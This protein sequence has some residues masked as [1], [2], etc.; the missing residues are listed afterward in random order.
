M[1][2]VYE[3]DVGKGKEKGYPVLHN[4]IDIDAARRPLK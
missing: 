2:R 3:L 1:L 4:Q